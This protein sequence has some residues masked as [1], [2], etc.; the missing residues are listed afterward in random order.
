MTSEASYVMK[1]AIRVDRDPNGAEHPVRDIILG[2]ERQR[3][4]VRDA[5]CLH[6]LRLIETGPLDVRDDVQ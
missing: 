2:L 5:V 1:S 3:A 4:V 6:G